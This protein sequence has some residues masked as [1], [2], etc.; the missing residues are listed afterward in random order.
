MIWK[1]LR[2]ILLRCNIAILNF[3]VKSCA[4]S[5]VV[6]VV[7]SLHPAARLEPASQLFTVRHYITRLHHKPL[8]HFAASPPSHCHPTEGNGTRRKSDARLSDTNSSLL[9]FAC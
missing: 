3:V 5:V 4:P 2:Q 8:R 9:R 1:M 7:S 6:L